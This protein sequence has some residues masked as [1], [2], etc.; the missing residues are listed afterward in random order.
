[1]FFVSTFC[2][3][4]L[5]SCDCGPYIFFLPTILVL[6][7]KTLETK[8][9][10]CVIKP[11]PSLRLSVNVFSL[12]SI[13]GKYLQKYSKTTGGEID[14]KLT[15]K[16]ISSHI[17][18]KNF[19]IEFCSTFLQQPIHYP[20]LYPVIADAK[21]ETNK[22]QTKTPFFL[23]FAKTTTDTGTEHIYTW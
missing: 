13:C 15:F 11:F 20:N 4:L 21:F 19:I 18:N 22:P 1:M 2:R 9:L 3:H 10:S 23:W 14:E 8:Y 12:L 6:P 5:F 16:L 7:N 17:C